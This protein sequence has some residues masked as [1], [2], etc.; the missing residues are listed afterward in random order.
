MRHRPGAP[1]SAPARS[2]SVR[3]HSSWKNRS[4]SAASIVTRSSTTRTAR[5]CPCARSSVSCAEAGI[6]AHNDLERVAAQLVL[7]NATLIAAQKTKDI[8]K[9][10]Q[11]YEETIA[12]LTRAEE[13]AGEKMIPGVYV[14]WLTT[15]A[16]KSAR[17][18]A[19]S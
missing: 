2:A 6:A 18:T 19:C 5:G 1:R 12:A 8:E 7:A 16:V 14:A 11:L 3:T 15:Y 4:K 13:S 17:P 10:T 9:R